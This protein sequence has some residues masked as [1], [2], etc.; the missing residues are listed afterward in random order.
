M[1]HEPSLILDNCLDELAKGRSLDE[2][3]NT[4]PEAADLRPI[5][6]LAAELRKLSQPE[7]RREAVQGLLVKAGASLSRC[8]PWSRSGSAVQRARRSGSHRPFWPILRWAGALAAC[9]VAAFGVSAAAS[10][11]IPGSLLYPIK[12]FTERVTFALTTEPGKR[13]ELRLSFADDRLEELIRSARKEGRIDPALLRQVH[14]ESEGALRDA[15]PLP[16]ARFKSFL[17]KVNLSNGYQKNVFL[18]VHRWVPTEDQGPIK[19]AISA[20]DERERWLKEAMKAPESGSRQDRS[21]GPEC[22]CD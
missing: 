16:E 12:L 22:D 21:W 20:C 6:S 15:R 5:L 3:L 18:Q 8:V 2:C 4:V 17:S 19:K 7:P 10:Q 1:A 9:A 11:S 13:A 14:R